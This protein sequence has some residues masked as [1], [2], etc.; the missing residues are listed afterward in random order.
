MTLDIEQQIVAWGR[1]VMG[2]NGVTESVITIREDNEDQLWVIVL[3]VIDGQTKR[4]VEFMEEVFDVNTEQEDAFYVDS[5]LTL[6]DAKEVTGASQSNPVVIT[7]VAHGFSNSDVVRIRDVLGMVE[8]NNRSFTIGGVTAD[9]FTL[10]DEDGTANSPYV[11]GGNAN[12]EVIEISGLGHLEG[13]LVNT[14]GDGAS[15]PPQLVENGSITLS[16]A[17][18]IVHVGLPV[19]SLMTTMPITATT[20]DLD[21][22]SGIMQISQ[23]FLIVHRSLGGKVGDDTGAFNEILYREA[24]D[25]MDTAVPLFTGYLDNVL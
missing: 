18:S 6:D 20:G 7:A 4:Y 24:T 9:T 23:L 22:R 17:S 14:M 13:Q 2:G 12:K 1:H 19:V 21:S 5:G 16:S 15:Q 11:S 10:L 8:L 3:R 25:P